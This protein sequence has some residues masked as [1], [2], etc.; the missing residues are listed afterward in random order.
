MKNKTLYIVFS[1]L[2]HLLGW[3][4]LLVYTLIKYGAYVKDTNSI[5][6]LF[7]FSLVLIVWFLLRNLKGVAENGYAMTREL[8]RAARFVV[9]MI[10]VF[11]V[12]LVLDSNIGGITDIIT[13][14]TAGAI[15]GRMCGVVAYRMGPVYVRDCG[16]NRL[17]AAA[18]EE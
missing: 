4:G 16:I 10:F 17:V 15:L 7:G 2:K 1:I 3:V 9:P 11:I 18:E 5:V 6:I 14:F 8:A 12:V 13:F